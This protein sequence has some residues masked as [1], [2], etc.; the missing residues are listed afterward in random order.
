MKVFSASQIRA[1]DKYTIE[2][3]PISSIDLMERAAVQLFEWIARHFDKSTPVVLF[4]GTGNNGGDALALARLLVKSGFNDVVLYRLLISDRFS[5]D[6]IINYERLLQVEGIKVLA[7]SADDEFP[8]I[9]PQALVVDGIFGSGLSKPINGYWAELLNYINSKSANI[10]AIDIPSGLFPDDNTGNNGAVIT[11]QTTLT[12]Q[13]PKTTFFFAENYDVVGDW[14]LLNIGLSDDFINKEPVNQYYVAK[15]RAAQKLKVRNRFA[16]KGMFGHA[17]MIAGSY[18][19]M[20]AAILAS[21]ACM[22]TGVGLLTVHVPESGY[23]IMQTSVPEAMLCIDETEMNYCNRLEQFSVVGIGPGIGKKASMIQAFK[24]LLERESRPMVIDADAINM[25]ASHKELIDLIP[26]DSVLTPHPGEFDRLTHKHT[27]C[28][29]R[30]LSQKLLSK[31]LKICI[32]LKGAFTSISTPNGDVYFNSTGNP[33]MA[34]A[35]SGDV[36]TGIILSLL[37]Q[38]YNAVEASIIG[39][40][41]HGLA[42]DI[43]MQEYGCESLIASDIINSLGKAFKQLRK[44]VE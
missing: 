42:G 17:F 8:V 30:Y 29:E 38:G 2:H 34:T 15:K 31:K 13:F 24:T 16:H 26:E 37:A 14:Y 27:N 33:G 12:F 5:A 1:C 20:G 44:I 3:E 18:Q 7:I 11:A 41:L 19:M 4:A 36:L 10:L 21:K 23:E 35:G 6:H 40:Y 25:L 39:V 28:N 22:R 43:A 9:K 32:V